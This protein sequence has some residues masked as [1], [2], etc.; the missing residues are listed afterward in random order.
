MIDIWTKVNNI[1][2][3]GHCEKRAFNCETARNTKRFIYVYTRL[4]CEFIVIVENIGSAEG[5]FSTQFIWRL[6]YKSIYNIHG[7]SKPNFC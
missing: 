5:T 6:G 1:G 2:F 3:I 4:Y 7:F